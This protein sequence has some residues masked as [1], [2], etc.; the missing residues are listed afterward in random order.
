MPSL[1]S[2]EPNSPYYYFKGFNL[3]A[4][5]SW[6]AAVLLVIPGVSNSIDPG[7]IG[8][9]AE[10]LYN[11]GFLLSTTVAGLLYYVS[12]Q[13]WPV[14]LYPSQYSDRP[15]TWEHMSRTEG[16]FP[17]DELYP[18]HL[19]ETAVVNAGGSEDG[20]VTEVKGMD[21]SKW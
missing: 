6:L 10:R 2:T 12:C 18:E 14:M 21:K 9:A 4:F 15:K 7:S 11:M 19:I 8:I 5:G 1:Y 16:F 17:E 3:R 13:I 20:E